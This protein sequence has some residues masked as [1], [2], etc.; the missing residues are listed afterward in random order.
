MPF[1]PQVRAKICPKYAQVIS[2]ICSQYAKNM[3]EICPRYD[4]IWY[5]LTKSQKHHWVSD[6]PTW[7]QEILAHLKIKHLILK[8]DATSLN[9]PSMSWKVLLCFE[10]WR[11]FWLINSD[12]HYMHEKLEKIHH[13]IQFNSTL[14]SA[15]SSIPVR[16]KTSKKEI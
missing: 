1:C 12:Q 3:P 9:V 4:I 10:A 2:K 15:D 8:H 7:I 5:C 13:Q 14:V 6:S 11:C 16:R